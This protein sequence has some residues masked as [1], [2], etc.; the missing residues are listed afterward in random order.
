MGGML[1]V[2]MRAVEDAA[3]RAVIVFSVRKFTGRT[4]QTKA[5]IHPLAHSGIAVAEEA[6]PGGERRRVRCVVV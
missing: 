6:P 5:W 1:K 2:L 3:R 4:G